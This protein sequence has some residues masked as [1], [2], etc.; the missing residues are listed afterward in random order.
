[1]YCA[2]DNA[3]AP[4]DGQKP[5]SF[6][7]GSDIEIAVEDRGSGV[8]HDLSPKYCNNGGRSERDNGG[9]SERDD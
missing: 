1:V 7:P 4:I 3:R 9:C 6:R 8:A 2:V 5:C